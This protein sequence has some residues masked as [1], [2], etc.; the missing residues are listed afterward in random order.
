MQADSH[1]SVFVD[2]KFQHAVKLILICV[3]QDPLILIPMIAFFFTIMYLIELIMVIHHPGMRVAFEVY[4]SRQKK[5]G[6]WRHGTSNVAVS[7]LA[8]QYRIP[9]TGPQNEKSKLS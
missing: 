2:S 5:H 1:V 4:N 8:L 6:T 9:P 7:I 3:K